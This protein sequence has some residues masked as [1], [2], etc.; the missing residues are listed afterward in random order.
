MSAPEE[1]AGPDNPPASGTGAK[2]PRTWWP[3][4][5]LTLAGIMVVLL[6]VF[7]YL[8]DA[9]PVPDDAPDVVPFPDDGENIPGPEWLFLMFWIPFWY[10]KGR[11]K[12]WLWITSVIPLAL[13]LFLFL[14]PFLGKLPWNRIPGLA[15]LLARIRALRPGI[16]RSA[17]YGAPGLVFAALIF[18]SV[19]ASGHQAKVLGCDSC[20]NPAMGHRMA[21]PP[22]DVARYYA[23]DRAQQIGVGKYRAGKSSG[24]TE[25]GEMEYKASDKAEG[26]K[27]ADWQM[28]HMYE[29]TFTW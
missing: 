2:A 28:R 24:E 27:D 1:Q 8:A 15:A 25:E 29:P 9:Y 3:H 18:T 11:L 22:A 14:L 6:F 13:L 21:V 16:A 23:H 26:Y 7:G 12:Q 4:L 20:H 5:A 10:L 19:F 17:A